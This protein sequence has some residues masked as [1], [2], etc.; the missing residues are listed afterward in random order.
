MA[1][2]RACRRKDRNRE[3]MCDIHRE[4]NQ[5]S[6]KIRGNMMKMK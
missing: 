1:G 3:L 5:K 6:G 2:C 4:Q